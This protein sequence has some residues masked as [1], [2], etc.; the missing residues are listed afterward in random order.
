[1]NTPRA[2]KYAVLGGSFDPVH[3]GHLDL[4]DQVR[5]KLSLDMTLWVPTHLSPHKTSDQ[6]APANHRLEMLRLA[7]G[8][9]PANDLSEIELQ[10]GGVSYTVDTLEQIVQTPEP[11]EWSLILGLDSFKDMR[12]WKDPERIL[13]LSHIIVG[14]RP[15]I[16]AA[17]FTEALKTLPGTWES[18]ES[19][20]SSR[21]D[22]AV[23]KN[24]GGNKT[25][26][27]LSLN[28]RDISSS[29]IRARIRAG[30]SVKKML[31]PEVEKY[32]MRLLLYQAEA[33]PS[34][35]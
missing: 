2:K 9:N 5:Q 7:T 15:G 28:T 30:K 3:W 17:V 12:T 21:S 25:V 11:S 20:G 19:S 27:F 24:R 31:P 1:M 22:L 6:P 29:D 26:S 14:A 16:E 34:V 8:G 33:H 35:E 23:Y 13:Q 18:E 32:I 4:A 10:R